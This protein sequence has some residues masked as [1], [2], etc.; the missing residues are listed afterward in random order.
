[1]VIHFTTG[2]LDHVTSESLRDEGESQPP[3][4]FVQTFDNAGFDRKPT[5]GAL[6][7]LCS[8]FFSKRRDPEA[9]G[10]MKRVNCCDAA[11]P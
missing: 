11:V 7:R 6:A 5:Q 10:I 9:P 1:M 3:I 2:S 4:Y 8:L